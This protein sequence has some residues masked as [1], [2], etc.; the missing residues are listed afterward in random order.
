MT[1]KVV[2]L[3]EGIKAPAFTSES[4]SGKNIS[5]KDYIGKTVILYFYPKDN[6]PGCTTESCDF[7]DNKSK[8][9]RKK[10]VILGVSKDSIKS[11]LGFIE[12]QGLNFELLSDPDGE[13]CEKYGVWQEKKNYGR[14][15]MGI[16]RSTFIISP[17]GKI[18]KSLYGV[19]AKGHVEEILSYL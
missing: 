17:D 3:K 15:Y 14:S 2:Q 8:I 16:V 13:L 19:K 6:T 4:T 11:H 5:L 18:L 12:K 10:A 7:R 9:S 1:T